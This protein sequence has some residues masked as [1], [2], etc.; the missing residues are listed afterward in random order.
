MSGLALERKCLGLS[1]SHEVLLDDL[2]YIG[3]LL[4]WEVGAI[5][6]ERI[7]VEGGGTV[8]SAVGDRSFNFDVGLRV[9]KQS[10]QGRGLV[11]GEQH[12][13][14]WWIG[15][16]VV[17]GFFVPD[18]GCCGFGVGVVIRRRNLRERRVQV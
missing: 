10:R 17:L 1:D 11:L 4:T 8:A 9:R 13:C 7:G 16:W 12:G 2:V 3:A 5:G 15:V 18:E 14:L 6:E